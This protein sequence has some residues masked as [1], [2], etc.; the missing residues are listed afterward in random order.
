M[1]RALFWKVLVVAAVVSGTVAPQP[2]GASQA[3][4]GGLAFA[5]QAQLPTFPCAP[6]TPG[7][8][9]CQGTFTGNIVGSLSGMDGNI[10]WTIA[11]AAPVP[12]SS[13]ISY[14]YADGIEPGVRCMEGTAAAQ[15]TINATQELSQVQGVYGSV[16]IGTLPR[17]V[18]AANVTFRF[19]WYRV[20]TTANL[21]FDILRVVLSV[22]A[23]PT[24]STQVTVINADAT[25]SATGGVGYG[26]AVFSPAANTN[27]KALADACDGATGPIPLTAEVAGAIEFGALVQ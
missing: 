3:A 8:L 25:D 12:A 16:G 10:P 23:T 21:K 13:P 7:S 5:G 20:G 17:S 24:T 26:A 15:G 9:N 2:A 22:F 4:G 11:I 6:P 1:K 18:I 27:F 14:Y 19:S